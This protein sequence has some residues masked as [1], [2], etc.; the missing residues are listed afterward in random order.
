MTGAQTVDLDVMRE[1][2]GTVV[3]D[4]YHEYVVYDY[5]MANNVVQLWCKKRQTFYS[6]TPATFDSMVCI[7]GTI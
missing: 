4:G 2:L 5:S 1:A 3:S 7:S 6:V